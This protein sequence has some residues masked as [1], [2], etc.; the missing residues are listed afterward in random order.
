MLI[1]STY[2]L[3]FLF[4]LYS[5]VLFISHISDE[6]VFCP[7]M[8]NFYFLAFAIC[9]LPIHIVLIVKSIYP[10]IQSTLLIKVQIISHILAYCSS[11][12]NPL[13]YAFLSDNFRKAF[14]KVRQNK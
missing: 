7:W 1:K 2:K 4:I 6:F 10:D 13:L 9:W 14:R 3:P 11:C 5:L 8:I 12:V